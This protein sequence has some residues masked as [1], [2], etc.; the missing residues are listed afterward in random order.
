M[1]AD[2]ILDGGAVIDSSARWIVGLLCVAIWDTSSVQAQGTRNIVTASANENHWAILVGSDQVGGISG[3]SYRTN[4]VELLAATLPDCGYSKHR[5]LA[6]T[7]NAA[8]SGL[9]PSRANLMEHVPR[10]LRKLGAEDRL[11][12]YFAGRAF[13]DPKGELHLAPSDWSFSDP[14]SPSLAVSWLRQQLAACPA[15]LKMLVFDA[16]AGD[17]MKSIHA[18]PV[19]GREIGSAFKGMKDVFVLTS[20]RDGERSQVWTQVGQSV[21]GF[22]F[23]QAIAG[24]A[25]QDADRKVTTQELCT[26]VRKKVAVA[27]KEIFQESQTPTQVGDQ[28][29]KGKAVV[30]HPKS[31]MLREALDEMAD[32]LAD[33]AAENR[34]SRLGVPEFR[35]L[36]DDSQT[37]QLLG[38]TYG[39]LGRSC[40]MELER[41]LK[42]KAETVAGAFDVIP[43]RPLHSVLVRA[44]LSPASLRRGGTRGVTVLGK[45]IEAVVLGSFCARTG[46]VVTLRCDLQHAGN[47]RRLARVQTTALLNETDLA[48]IGLS[49]TIK[50][51]P[52][53]KDLPPPRAPSVD[54]PEVPQDPADEPRVPEFEPDSRLSPDFRM[55][56]YVG[57]EA[58]EPI[59]DAEH[60]YVALAKDEVYTIVVENRRIGP[61]YLRLLIDGLN[62]LP[63]SVEE[64]T[65]DDGIQE[66]YR[67]AQFVALDQARAWRMDARSLDAEASVYE[68]QGFYRDIGDEQYEWQTFK[69][70]E[71]SQSLAYQQAYSEQIGLITAAFYEVPRKGSRR[72]PGTIGTAPGETKQDQLNEYT[73]TPVGRLL[74]VVNLHYVEP[75]T[76]EQLRQ[77]VPLS[78]RPER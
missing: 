61:V 69:V 25:D 3:E 72:L 24:H 73:E 7:P 5:I 56:I 37:V 46:H 74:A 71:A 15:Q 40:A 50:P 11:L 63:E 36:G 48:S 18:V 65:P 21:F 23:T 77:Q 39:L 53:P 32:R 64:T 20:C 35:P 45:K 19:S 12:V 43:H 49:G 58:R 76:L 75:N 17:W 68:I 27:A 2:K 70:V 66:V 51:R 44:G 38:G 4:D 13:R 28:P 60:Q 31:T 1:R 26:Y 52:K 42:A 67:P 62:T 22:W 6:M 41:R 8:E 14:S 55:T 47:Q 59:S 34:V 57:D 10:F 29:A 16:S 54:H 78:N 9:R 30:S 33:A